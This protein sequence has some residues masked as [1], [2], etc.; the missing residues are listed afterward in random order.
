MNFIPK[1][2]R[3][4]VDQHSRK[5]E[6]RWLLPFTKATKHIEYEEDSMNWIWL[7]GPLALFMLI[8]CCFTAIPSQ[9]VNVYRIEK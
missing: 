4:Y 1:Y 3:V 8:I 2:V 7:L 6:K 9:P 5:Y